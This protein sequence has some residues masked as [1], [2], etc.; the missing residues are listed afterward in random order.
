MVAAL[1]IAA[2]PNRH[3]PPAIVL[4]EPSREGGKVKKRT[5]CNRSGWAK[6]VVDGFKTV[7]KGGTA[8]PAGPKAFTIRRAALPH[9]HAAA[10]L[11]TLQIVSGLL[12]A[13]DGG[14]VAAEVFEGNTA[15][16][17]TRSVQIAKL[18]ERLRLRLRFT[19]DLDH[20]VLV[21]DRG[22]ITQVRIEKDPG[23]A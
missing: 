14:P 11:G 4:R 2:V 13:A 7:L 3:S 12:C 16:P 21:G 6:D 10:V 5:L 23:S 17:P 20:V 19:H 1:D 9:G 8:V 22:L 18:K 15:D